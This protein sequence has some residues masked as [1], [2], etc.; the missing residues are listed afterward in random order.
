MIKE[1]LEEVKFEPRERQ[2]YWEERVA[3]RGSSRC[4]HSEMRR[5]LTQAKT[6]QK[7]SLA[8]APRARRGQWERIREGAGPM[9]SLWILSKVE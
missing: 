2:E 9:E 8:R 1:G 4:K 7:A 5:C 6:S 3:D